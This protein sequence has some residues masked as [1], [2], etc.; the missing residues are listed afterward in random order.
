MKLICLDSAPSD[1]CV[2]YLDSTPNDSCVICLDSAPNDSCV[3]CLDSAP[4]DSCVICLDRY[5]SDSCA[6]HLGYVST[7]HVIRLL[8]HQQ[9]HHQDNYNQGYLPLKYV[10]GIQEVYRLP[11]SCFF[12]FSFSLSLVFPRDKHTKHHTIDLQG[13]RPHTEHRTLA[14]L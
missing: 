12:L 3:I 4:N 7:I 1:S 5:Q 11:S 9:T 6:T 13:H 2:I 8:L 14:R 10:D